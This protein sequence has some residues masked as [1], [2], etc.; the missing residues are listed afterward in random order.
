MKISRTLSIVAI[1]ALLATAGYLF[2]RLYSPN[3]GSSDSDTSYSG[4]ITYKELIGK[5]APDFNLENIDG[6]TI[7]LSEYRGKNVILF[8]NEGA[9]CYPSCWDQ[10]ASFVRDERFN[11]DDVIVFSIVVDTKDE[12]GE[13]FNQVPELSKAE[14]LFATNRA[15]SSAYDVLS[16]P[17]SM[18]PPS[19]M[20]PDGY[21]GHTYLLIDKEGVVRFTL[22][23]PKMGMW[24]NKLAD[25]LSKLV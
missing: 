23:D 4:Y 13:I 1:V 11:T 18:H 9:M 7:K 8:F 10:M 19:A 25:E 15:V 20:H 24:N 6:K 2:T 21:P 5:Q 12:W 16:L 22:D 14:I 3:T 17:S